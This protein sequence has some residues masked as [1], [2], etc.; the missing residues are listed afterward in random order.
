[1][2]YYYLKTFGKL[3]VWIDV[4]EKVDILEK[5]GIGLQYFF[6]TTVLASISGLNYRFCKYLNNIGL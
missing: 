6:K 4:F 5:I 2:G 1:M 3:C